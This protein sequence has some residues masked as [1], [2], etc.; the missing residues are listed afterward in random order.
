MAQSMSLY[1]SELS[2]VSEKLHDPLA[3]EEDTVLGNIVDL[4]PNFELSFDLQALLSETLAGSPIGGDPISEAQQLFPELLGTSPDT[5]PDQQHGPTSSTTPATLSEPTTTTDP[6][7]TTLSYVVKDNSMPQIVRIELLNNPGVGVTAATEF[8]E[9]PSD[10]EGVSYG[11]IP[12]ESALTSTAHAC[13]T[14]LELDLAPVSPTSSETSTTASTYSPARGGRRTLK[15]TKDKVSSKRHLDKA[16][17]EYK[18]RRERN[19]IA[20]RK[21]RDKAK[22]R[23]NETNG[24][25]KELTTKND[26]LQKKVDL[27]TK[28]LNVLKG[29]FS[30]IGSALPADL[31]AH[32]TNK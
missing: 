9:A 5:L 20:V 25:V 13:T 18:E 8:V 29:L 21:S 10:S 15:A 16:S 24:K 7:I 12:P 1:E 4:D 22:I 30:N 3:F 11:E 27:L 19:N 23:Q 17:C 26:Q 6:T 28:E 32:F 31:K 14:L 2:A